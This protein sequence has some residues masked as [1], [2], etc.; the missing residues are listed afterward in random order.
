MVATL[1]V[2]IIDGVHLFQ[3]ECNVRFLSKK[4]FKVR[5]LSYAE[6]MNGEMT[7]TADTAVII[8]G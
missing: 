6:L 8:D 4:I 3:R 1:V 2:I 7:L 5:I